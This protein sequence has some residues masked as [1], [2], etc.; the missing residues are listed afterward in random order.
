[1]A[2]LWTEDVEEGVKVKKDTLQDQ[3]ACVAASGYFQALIAVDHFQRWLWLPTTA[4][5]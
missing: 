3:E 5:N 4:E 1:M 2:V